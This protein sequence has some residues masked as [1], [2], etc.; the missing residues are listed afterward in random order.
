M[1]SP[2]FS[3]LSFPAQGKSHQV[4]QHELIQATGVRSLL[5]MGPGGEMEEGLQT[6]LLIC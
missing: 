2:S 4:Q 6:V 1:G 3:P 5:K